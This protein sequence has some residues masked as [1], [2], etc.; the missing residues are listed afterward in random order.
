MHHLETVQYNVGEQLITQS[1]M[2]SVIYFIREGTVDIVLE[3]GDGQQIRICSAIDGT[4]VG[5]AAFL[6][7]APRS[8]SVV[9]TT[10]TT[11]YRLTHEGMEDIRRTNPA[12]T[13]AFYEYLGKTLANRLALANKRISELLE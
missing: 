9:A 6:T 2:A 8:A 11:A 12:I 13:I 4:I 7:N 5:E 10:P 3:L 1:E